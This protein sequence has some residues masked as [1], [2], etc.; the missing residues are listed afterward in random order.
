MLLFSKN[1]KQRERE[2]S[3]ATDR[4]ARAIARAI[5]Q[6]QEKAAGWLGRKFG[7]LPHPAQVVCLLLF[8]LALGSASG[9]ILALAVLP[10]PR[11][12][13]APSLQHM[14]PD[15]AKEP[16]ASTPAAP[17]RLPEQEHRPQLQGLPD[18][19]GTQTDTIKYIP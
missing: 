17:S 16:G 2:N 14:V 3:P 10:G 5:C 19:P 4:K 11:P 7:A 15:Q 8:C 13:V 6:G 12:A 18:S 1:G 9:W